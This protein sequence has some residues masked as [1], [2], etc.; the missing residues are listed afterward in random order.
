MVD[1]LRMTE[2]SLREELIKRGYSPLSRFAVFRK[3]WE[4]SFLGQLFSYV[5]D[6]ILFTLFL[7]GC[8]AMSAGAVVVT[9][10]TFDAMAQ[11]PLYSALP[12]LSVSLFSIIFILA[13]ALF[14]MVK[15]MKLLS[16][17]RI[18]WER[19]FLYKPLD[20]VFIVE[21]AVIPIPQFVRDMYRELSKIPDTN[22]FVEYADGAFLGA[23]RNG[24]MVYLAHWPC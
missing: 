12:A 11:M 23:E 9:F 1:T 13:A 19:T 4:G 6:S 7:V 10:Y 20:W 15:A 2:S 17:R 5:P 21:G 3:R 8:L 22:F 14:S 24:E 18:V 16:K